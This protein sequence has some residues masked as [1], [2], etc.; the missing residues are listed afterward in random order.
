M[1]FDR[2]KNNHSS[3]TGRDIIASVALV[4]LLLVGC[5]SVDTQ[6]N[7]TGLR[8]YKYRPP[9]AVKEEDKSECS[10]RARSK[11]TEAL[12]KEDFK[13]EDTFGRLFGFFGALIAV[14]AAITHGNII[15]ESAY[16]AEMKACLKEKGYS[17][18]E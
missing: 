5:A 14:G 10:S 18:P 15:T 7:P 11:A 12:A 9:V 3:H 4:A 6:E 8:E 17:L 16:E 2:L 13:A 1:G